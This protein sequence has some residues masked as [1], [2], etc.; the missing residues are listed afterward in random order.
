MI[1]QLGQDFMDPNTISSMCNENEEP[2]RIYGDDKGLIYALVD[3]EDF[4]FLS[5]WKW[6]PKFSRGGKKIYLRRNLQILHEASKVCPETGSRLRKRTQKTLFLHQAVMELKGDKP[7]T[8]DHCIID[9]RNGNSMDC[10]KS[11]I[12]WV[13]RSQN[14][15]NIRGCLS[16]HE[17]DQRYD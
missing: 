9:H 16:T 12:R 17:W 11:N 8:P 4:Q 3:R 1:S 7:Q 2:C 15:Q 13:T 14:N 5:Q 6:S 10:R